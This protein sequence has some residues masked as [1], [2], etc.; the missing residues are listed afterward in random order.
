[1]DYHLCDVLQKAIPYVKASTYVLCVFL[2]KN[3]PSQVFRYQSVHPC[4]TIPNVLCK[5]FKFFYDTYPFPNIPGSL[6]IARLSVYNGMLSCAL[7]LPKP[8]QS[9]HKA[10]RR[11]IDNK[12]SPGGLKHGIEQISYDHSFFVVA[13]HCPL[14][15]PRHRVYC[16]QVVTNRGVTGDPGAD[17]SG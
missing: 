11:T 5:I 4:L 13:G 12:K 3:I 9:Y 2:H 7:L 6:F 1:M 15:E 8:S 14:H 10:P 16:V 17:Q